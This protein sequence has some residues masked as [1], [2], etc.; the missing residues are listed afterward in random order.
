[1]PRRGDLPGGRATREVERVREDQLRVQRGLRRRQQVD[2][3]LCHR[4]QRAERTHRITPSEAC[5]SSDAHVSLH[6]ARFGFVQLLQEH[7]HR[8][9]KR[10]TWNVPCNRTGGCNMPQEGWGAQP[11]QTSSESSEETTTSPIGVEPTP[12]VAP[13]ITATI[14]ARARKR[15]TSRSR[16]TGTRKRTTAKRSTA[17]RSTAKRST[18]KRTT[19]KRTTAKRRTTRRK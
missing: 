7:T 4:A 2:R 14:P 6:V 10:V 3:R 5:V 15:S 11:P 18:A 9:T 19:A 16:T 1:M 13:E 8:R 12:A 17:K